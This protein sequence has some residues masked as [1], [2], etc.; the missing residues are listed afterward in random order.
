MP[1]ANGTPDEKAENMHFGIGMQRQIGAKNRP[2]ACK[3]YQ[4]NLMGRNRRVIVAPL[5]AMR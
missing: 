3:C 5:Q 2:R 1:A 4:S